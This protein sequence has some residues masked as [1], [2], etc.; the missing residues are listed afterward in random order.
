MT[1]ASIM[2]HVQATPE[3]EARL[4]V[5]RDLADAFDATLIGVGAEALSPAPFA[6]PT[7]TM[8][9]EWVV[10]MRETVEKNLKDAHA[11]YNSRTHSLSKKP[12][13]CSG[14]R[15][16][17]DALA[18][19]A[20]GADLIVGGHMRTDQ[21][22]PYRFIDLGRLVIA[23]GRPVLITPKDPPPLSGKTVLLAWKDSREARR[24][25][26]DAMPFFRR[27]E[28]VVVLELCHED[29]A[30]DAAIRTGDVV[31]ALAR[32]GVSARAEVAVTP[33]GDGH[34][35]LRHASLCGA[36]L[37]VCGGYGH[38][39]LGEWVFGGVTH[40]LLHQDQAY[41]LLSH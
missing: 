19:A 39:R 32:H 20:R 35:I 33:E 12:L 29:D 25:M 1:F 16:P 24:A 17:G 31:A 15:I 26:A 7:G 37:I 41:V 34:Q 9:G 28:T 13:W 36:D 22:D 4:Q 27:A 11:L 5:A 30:E 6:D 10:A 40:D 2:T 38:T 8:S 14:M 21:N 23:A 3:G 18:A